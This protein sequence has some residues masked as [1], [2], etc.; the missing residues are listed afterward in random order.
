VHANQVYQEYIQDRNHVH[1]N[2]TRWTSL[3]G[4]VRSL[5]RDGLCDI[6]EAE[7]G[8]FI[9]WIDN[10]PKT[11]AKQEALDKKERM[12]KDQSEIEQQMLEEQIKRGQEMSSGAPETVS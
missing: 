1:M 9:T 7:K 4:F 3:A 5:G 2:S 10:S 6:E 11:L 12:F 8:W